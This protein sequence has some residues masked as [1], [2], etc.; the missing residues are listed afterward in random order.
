MIHDIENMKP[1]PFD[2][3]VLPGFI[4][5]YAVRSKNM[6]KTARRILFVSGAFMAMRNIGEYRTAV[7]RIQSFAKQ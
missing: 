6:R 7:E 4:M 2:T 3:Y 5:W 1:R